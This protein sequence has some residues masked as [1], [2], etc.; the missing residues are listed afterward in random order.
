MSEPVCAVVGVGPG[1]GAAFVRRFV[2]A[3]Q[4]VAM[5]TRSEDTL[6]AL[7]KEISGSLGFACDVTDTDRVAH[8]F[9]EVRDALGPVQTMVYNAGAG[10][11]S[12]LD[13]ATL[14][15][16]QQAWEVNARGLFVA[17]KAVV[18]QMRDLGGGNLVVIG[19]TASLRG[20]A[21]TAPFA[22]P[23]TTTFPTPIDRLAAASRDS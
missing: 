2:S 11:F 6:R 10:Q 4:Q 18:P 7:E 13:N 23:A 9:E 1:N 3:G 5:L 22:T 15:T 16:F 20:G 19:A 14:A 17:A 21:N 12:N 8:A